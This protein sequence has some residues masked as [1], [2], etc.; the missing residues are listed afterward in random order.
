L[1]WTLTADDLNVTVGAKEWV[2]TPVSAIGPPTTLLRLVHLDVP[3]DQIVYIE[4][5]H[6]CVRLT[7]GEELLDELHR[8][9]GPPSLGS[10]LDLVTLGL[11][12]HTVSV[13]KVRNDLL[14]LLNISQ[15]LLRFLQ[16]PSSN[17]RAGFECVLVM[18]PEIRSPC[19]TRLSK[20][21]RLTRVLFD[22]LL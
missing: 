5:L 18:T 10:L 12:G 3:H 22:H 15:K 13:T 21:S 14:V 7:V 17:R 1:F 6:V 16:F 20:D 8:L 2:D 9:S 4:S 11:P 19:T